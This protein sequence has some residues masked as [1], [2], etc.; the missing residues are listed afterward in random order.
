MAYASFSDFLEL[1]KPRL[2][3][4]VLVTTAAGFWLGMQDPSQVWRLIPTLLGTALVVGGANTMNEWMERAED[5]LMRRT[6]HR[7]L[8]ARRL[9]PQ[10]AVRFGAVISVAGI[11]VLGLCVN[12]L[13]AGIA[14]ISWMSYVL[15]YTPLKPRTSLCT[16]VGAIPGALPPVI[17]WTA[18]R[19]ALG[20]GAW[21]LFAILYV[22]QLP[23]F[24]ALA[25]LYRDDY[26]RA[27]FRM[28]PLMESDGWMTARQI[29][30][31]GVVLLPASLVPT[32]AGLTGAAYFYGALL[33]S[34]VLFI[35]A[36]RAAWIRSLPS[37]RQLFRASVLYLPLLLGLLAVDRAPL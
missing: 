4:L 6:Q 10:A 19:H 5:A 30:L 22:W 9:A 32:M 35:V 17:G 8:P 21:A 3:L 36:A 14:L 34:L 20:V 27:G 25:V 26:A 33:L 24:L 28:L 37:A 13:S 23:H 31:Y 16:L 12:L 11:L 15:A 29:V 7:P 1:T 2:S 18:A